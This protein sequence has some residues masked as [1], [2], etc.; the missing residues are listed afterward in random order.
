MV[1]LKME[2]LIY[3]NT[4]EQNNYLQHRVVKIA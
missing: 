3:Q 1:N 2:M 4:V